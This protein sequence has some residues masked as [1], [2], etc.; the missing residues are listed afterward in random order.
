VHNRLWDQHTVCV[1]LNNSGRPPERSDVIVMGAARCLTRSFGPR[2]RYQSKGNVSVLKVKITPAM[3]RCL[4]PCVGLDRSEDHI[5]GG[6]GY[7]T[8]NRNE[9]YQREKYVFMSRARPEQ[10]DGDFI[11][12]CE[13]I[14]WNPEHLTTFLA[15]AVCYRNSF[16]FVYVRTSHETH[17][18]ASTACYVDSFAFY[19]YLMLVPTKTEV[20]YLGLHLD[21]KLTWKTHIRMKRQ[22]LWL[23]VRQMNWLIG[24]RS[25]LSLENKS[26]YIRRFL[27][28]SGPTA[29]SCGG[30]QNHPTPKYCNR[31][32]QKP[33]EV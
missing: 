29:L 2:E 8:F 23:K 11:A 32:N 18:W 25:Q 5:L 20:K 3:L 14:V 17:L 28:P 24:Y 33:Y 16:T 21:Q 31:F 6:G 19:M 13:P 9:Y 1:L 12:I 10:E 15:S 7:T 27:S 22:Q 26:C 30:A 4:I